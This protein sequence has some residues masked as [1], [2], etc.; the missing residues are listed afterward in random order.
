MGNRKAPKGYK[1][2]PY[3][4]LALTG[5]NVGK[6]LRPFRFSQQ[7]GLP[8]ISNVYFKRRSGN[9]L[10]RSELL[11]SINYN[12]QLT[13]LS[14]PNCKTDAGAAAEIRKASTVSEFIIHV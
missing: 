7:V 9:K 10:V 1:R 5:L 4:N 2:G 14:E 8:R 3:T 12:G 11:Q 6:G 13:L